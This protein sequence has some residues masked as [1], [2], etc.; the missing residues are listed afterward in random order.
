[1]HEVS[2]TAHRVVGGGFS[3]DI[4]YGEQ[5]KEALINLAKKVWALILAVL[6]TS[7][8]NFFNSFYFPSSEET[9]Q[10]SLLHDQVRYRDWKYL[11][12]NAA[13]FGN[14]T[15]LQACIDRRPYR[16]PSSSPM[17]GSSDNINS[18]IKDVKDIDGA[19]PIHA[20]VLGHD[21]GDN[22]RYYIQMLLNAGCEINA[23][24]MRGQTAMH[25]AAAK[26]DVAMVRFLSQHG[27]D[28]FAKD[29]RQK[30]PLHRAAKYGHVDVVSTLLTIAQEKL[31]ESSAAYLEARDIKGR[32]SYY[33]AALNGRKE[34]AG[35]LSSLGADTEITSVDNRHVST[36]VG[37]AGFWAFM[38]CYFGAQIYGYKLDPAKRDAIMQRNYQRMRLST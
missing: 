3:H 19:T 16:I 23:K 6:P 7:S 14:Q 26:G 22:N 18:D 35:L 33:L 34:V 36:V 24:E 1:M 31:R 4:G 37:R 21:W 20:A 27:A 17:V 30:T 13:F 5:I 9:R 12:L 29:D 8:R 28:I 15:A 2:A 38:R 10:R 11:A 32:T 25:W